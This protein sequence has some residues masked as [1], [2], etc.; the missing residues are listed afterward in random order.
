LHQAPVSRAFKDLPVSSE[1]NNESVPDLH[2]SASRSVPMLRR[3]FAQNA[4]LLRE[5][6]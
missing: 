3:V 1:G 2:G 6:S 5:I 4:A